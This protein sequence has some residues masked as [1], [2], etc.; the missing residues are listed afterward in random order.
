[1]LWSRCEVRGEMG[2]LGIEDTVCKERGLVPFASCR[3]A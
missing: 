3:K 2:E 1:M